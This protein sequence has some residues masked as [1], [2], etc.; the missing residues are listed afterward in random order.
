MLNDI[1]YDWCLFLPLYMAMYYK[2]NLRICGNVSKKLYRNII[3]YVSPILC[4][5]SDELES[6]EIFV[7]GFQEI[8]GS[9]KVNG[10]GLS[11]G[12]D[13]LAT[14]Y[15]YYKEERD[16]DYKLTHLFFL[17]CGWHG[18]IESNNTIKLFEMRAA[19][20][21]RAA[22][23]IGLP[24]VKIDSNLHAFLY[25]LDDKASYFNIYSIIFA[26]EKA[27]GKYYLSSTFSYSEV[28]KYGIKALNR[29]FSEYGDPMTLPLLYT[30]NTAIVS[31]GCQYKRSYKTKMIS[32]WVISKKYLN[33]CSLHSDDLNVNEKNCS[34]C[35]KCRRTLLALDAAGKIKDYG[36]VFDLDVYYSDKKRILWS[37]ASCYGKDAFSTDNYD[38]CKKA[39][40]KMPPVAVAKII[41]VLFKI[42]KYP[43]KTIIN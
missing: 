40:I 2:T 26:L 4:S 5:F 3:D 37:L 41:K 43:I 42:I 22:D 18:T 24:F 36:E 10:T 23:D 34:K 21:K 32:D 7:D 27:V 13:S 9:K 30:D 33:V 31:D 17:N 8:D 19:Q 35:V 25:D 1:T 14:V 6:V 39:G 20:A 12:V 38:S 11:C 29:D 16:P 28:M 15:K